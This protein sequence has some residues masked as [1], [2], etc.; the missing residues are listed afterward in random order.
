MYN[1][2]FSGVVVVCPLQA[3]DLLFGQTKN[4]QTGIY[5]FFVKAHSINEQDQRLVGSWAG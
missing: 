1:Y 3:C 5:C 4:Y 2:G